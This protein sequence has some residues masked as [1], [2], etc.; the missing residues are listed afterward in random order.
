MDKYLYI[1]LY[2]TMSHQER[3]IVL[4][5]GIFKKTTSTSEA[6]FM[7]TGM[8]IGAGILG[9]PYAVSRVGIKIGVL[10]ILVLGL[11]MLFLNLMIGE[12]AARTK[13][14]LQL[15]GLAGKYIGA[16]AKHVLS[17]T[18][19][20]SA[21]GAL[22]AYII[23]VGE[24]LANMFGGSSYSWSF[25]FWFVAGFVVWRGLQSA[26]VTQKI[27][28][29]ILI[30]I[31]SCLSFYLL[32]HADVSHFKY[33]NFGNIF[34]PYGI[35]L[36]A[37]HGAPAIV[38]AH[39]LLPNKPDQFRR[40][41]IIGTLIPI[42]VY[43]LFVLAT[44]GVGGL[45][46]TEV[47]T[48]GLGSRFGSGVLFFG[49]LFAVLAMG[50]SFVGLGIALKETLVWDSGIK[51]VWA[52]VSVVFLPMIFFVLGLRSFIS[53][54]NVV[55]GVFVGIESLLMVLMYWRA[56]HQ[57]ILQPSSYNLHHVWLLVLPVILVFAVMT[58]YNL[59]QFFIN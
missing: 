19:V 29:I 25:G 24:A 56:K 27:L 57:K 5:R 3:K 55:G 52:N 8:T 20:L 12:I 7:I 43:I 21:F 11:V 30:V 17:V 50:T 1:I 48:I 9:L 44:V 37:L 53:I 41:L 14:P 54:L 38:E 46:T 34:F 42:F 39:A 47:A 35:V 15:P 31:I 33:L 10:Y 23:G 26:R 40:A 22:L 51:N 32:P 6:V 16:W 28:S 58:W 4:H 18:V 59:F 13:E 49:N 36:F 45:Q 2:I